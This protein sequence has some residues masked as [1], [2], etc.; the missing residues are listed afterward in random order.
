MRKIAVVLLFILGSFSLASVWANA[1]AGGQLIHLPIVYRPLPSATPTPTNTPL[2]T[3]I[4]TNTPVPTNT[5]QP[6]NTPVSQPTFTP[7]PT[8]PPPGNCTVCTSNV[9]NCTHFATQAQAQACHDYCWSIVGYDVHQLDADGD[10]EAC[11]SL[12]L[13][14]A[15]FFPPNE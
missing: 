4:P 12:P 6:T 3:P 10:G 8:Q 14:D 13:W 9:Y 1:P 15:I 7:V 11:E 5:P 2:P